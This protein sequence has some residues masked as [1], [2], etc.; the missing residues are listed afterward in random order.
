[1]KKGSNLIE[2]KQNK[3]QLVDTDLFNP[4]KKPL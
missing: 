4:S 3:Y 1:M 2:R